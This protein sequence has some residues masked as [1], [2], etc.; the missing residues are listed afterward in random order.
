[1][2]PRT[3]KALQTR[4]IRWQSAW[5]IAKVSFP[6]FLKEIAPRRTGVRTMP[7]DTAE[8]VKKVIVQVLKVSPAQV[9]PKARFAT[10]L[11]AESL[12]SVRLVAA[13]DEEFGIEMDEDAALAV[14]SVADAIAFIDKCREKNG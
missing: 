6:S 9:L 8:R 13:F 5:E 12:D 4:E 2:K 3:V 11:G 1:M 14:K 10:D 7:A